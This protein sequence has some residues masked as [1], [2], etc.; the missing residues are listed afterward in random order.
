MIYMLSMVAKKKAMEKA[1]EMFHEST[2]STGKR[3]TKRARPWDHTDN[4]Y[5]RNSDG[6]FMLFFRTIMEM[7]KETRLGIWSGSCLSETSDRRMLRPCACMHAMH[8]DWK[9]SCA[10]QQQRGLHIREINY[11]AT[12]IQNFREPQHARMLRHLPSCSGRSNFS[13]CNTFVSGCDGM[14][15]QLNNAPCRVN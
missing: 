1:K 10:R 3:I 6:E 12:T 7:E 5:E 8:T 11:G 9:N 15:I 2:K 4:V 13:A 14:K